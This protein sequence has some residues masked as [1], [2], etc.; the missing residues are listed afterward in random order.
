LDGHG[1]KDVLDPEDANTEVVNWLDVSWNRG[2]EGL[3][4]GGFLKMLSTELRSR[5]SN[6]GKGGS[7][8][9]LAEAPQL[10]ER[11]PPESGFLLPFG[12]AC[13][14]SQGQYELELAMRALL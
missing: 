8:R 11:Y 5:R 10:V 2:V 9:V 1:S 3:I 13:V 6:I 14:R 4:T 12:R 7:C